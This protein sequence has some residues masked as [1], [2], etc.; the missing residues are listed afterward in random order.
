MET[1]MRFRMILAA[2]FV[3]CA[4]AWGLFAG[5][6][7]EHPRSGKWHAVQHAH[8]AANPGCAVCGKKGTKEKPN[9]VHH[10]LP[11]HL[12]PHLELEPSNLI[13]LCH[14]HHLTFGHLM[15][16]RAFN[17]DVRKDAAIWREKIKQRKYEKLSCRDCDC[18]CCCATLTAVWPP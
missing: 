15:D 17:P 9:Q 3:G 8:L 14:D 6:P 1:R 4:L 11:F 16:Y 13:T 12:Y 2:L 5:A 7:P 18:G 10:C